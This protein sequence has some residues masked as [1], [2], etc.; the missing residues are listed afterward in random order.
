MLV[1]EI[2]HYYGETR[3]GIRGSIRD[4]WKKRKDIRDN[5]KKAIKSQRGNRSNKERVKRESI[6]N[7][8]WETEFNKGEA[9]KNI[10]E[11]EMNWFN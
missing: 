9:L 3:I 8:E 7:K 4:R 1:F 11:N 5:E 2:Y 6:R 10:K